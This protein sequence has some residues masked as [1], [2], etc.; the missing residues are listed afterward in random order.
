MSQIMLSQMF[1]RLIKF[2]DKY[3]PSNI[4]CTR[5]CKIEAITNSGNCSFITYETKKNDTGLPIRMLIKFP[6]DNLHDRLEREVIVLEELKK[7][8]KKVP[9]FSQ[10]FMKLSDYFI[11]PGDTRSLF[12][13]PVESEII[14]Q[15]IAFESIRNPITLDEKLNNF[16]EQYKE[17]AKLKKMK[18][19]GDQYYDPIIFEDKLFKYE[20]EVLNFL[21]SLN[22]FYKA[23]LK[24]S[25]NIGFV[26]NDLHSFNVLCKGDCLY[27]IDYGRSYININDSEKYDSICKEL[28]KD[29]VFN[30]PLGNCTKDIL[31]NDRWVKKPTDI[32]KYDAILTDLGGLSMY[33]LKKSYDVFKNLKV[34]KVVNN[35]W[36]KINENNE[37]FEIKRPINTTDNPTKYYY[38]KESF[39]WMQKLQKLL[40]RLDNGENYFG[41]KEL[42]TDYNEDDTRSMM[43]SGGTV[44][45]VIFNFIFSNKMVGGAYQDFNEILPNLDLEFNEI[46]DIDEELDW[47]LQLRDNG[48]DND[49]I[50]ENIEDFNKYPIKDDQEIWNKILQKKMNFD[51]KTEKEINKKFNSILPQEVKFKIQSLNRYEFPIIDDKKKDILPQFKNIIRRTSSENVNLVHG[52]DN[53]NKKYIYLTEDPKHKSRKIYVE[54]NGNKYIIKEKTK[55][56]LKDFK[57]KY[58]YIQN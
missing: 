38:I 51:S 34:G 32:G 39:F 49:R 20:K 6:T 44:F 18:K 30:R 27:L 56:Y 52:G 9:E 33:I 43:T 17:L 50:K 7:Y 13:K 10:Y 28:G 16:N 42:F 23:I 8:F 53:N 36:Q 35:R 26:H 5:E 11:A 54:K 58:R 22:N 1:S 3:K 31:L 40:T 25:K 37:S 2:G 24:L 21:D 29:T 15:C 55:L 48:I 57:G 41:W 46:N 14:Y 19:T 45:P 4:D 47:M 12:L